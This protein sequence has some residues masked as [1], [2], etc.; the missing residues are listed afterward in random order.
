MKSWE[1]TSISW[2]RSSIKCIRFMVTSFVNLIG[3]RGRSQVDMTN[4]NSIWLINLTSIW[5]WINSVERFV[6]FKDS[7]GIWRNCGDSRGTFTDCWKKIIAKDM[8]ERK[9]AA[10]KLIPVDSPGFVEDCVWIDKCKFSNGKW[11]KSDTGWMCYVMWMYVRD[12]V[13]TPFS[14][15]K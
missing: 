3:F 14:P 13:L 7:A 6:A 4:I 8:M 11:G 10:V 1:F 9:L 2:T 12:K 5:R 15:G